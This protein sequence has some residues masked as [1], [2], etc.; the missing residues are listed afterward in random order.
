MSGNDSHELDIPPS[1][2]QDHRRALAEAH[3]RTQAARVAVTD[4]AALLAEQRAELAALRGVLAR[5]PALSA[6][7][8]AFPSVR[9]PMMCHAVVAA[10]AS[11]QAT[12]LDEPSVLRLAEVI[13]QA[14][15]LG[16][17][18]LRGDMDQA[19]VRANA[20]LAQARIAGFDGVASAAAQMVDRLARGGTTGPGT[21][22]QAVDALSVEIDRV[23]SMQFGS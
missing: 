14:M 15:V 5:V 22:G 16:K 11:A 13:Q 3:Y 18:V 7:M 19:R 1:P 8:G 21:Y 20:I 12:A 23:Q 9:V 6:V 4:T 10:S 17:A 2:Q